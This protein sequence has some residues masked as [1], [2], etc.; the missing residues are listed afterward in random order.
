MPPAL[1]MVDVRKRYGANRAL[2][3]LNLE[4][5]TGALTGLVG[6]NGA[7]KTTTFAVVGGSVRPDG[8]QVDLLGEGPFDPD[9]HAGRLGLLPQDCE[10]SPYTPVR[11]LLVHY[12]R[13]QGMERRKA[14]YHA[15]R[16]LEAVDLADRAGAKIR[17][18]SHGMRRR[19]AVAQALLGDPSL[20]LLD[21]PTSGL[22]PHLVVRMRELFA[23]ERGRR[24]LVISSHQLAELEAVCDHVVFMEAGRVVRAGALAEVT[25]RGTT[26]RISLERQDPALLARAEAVARSTLPDATVALKDG[27]LV[28]DAPPGQDAGRLNAA[29]LP[30]LIAAGLPIH[31]VRAGTSLEQRYMESRG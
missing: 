8:G 29:L 7:G 5:P 4:I 26:V 27:L 28:V 21:E 30:A 2:D 31:E 9:R 14:E 6:P 12:G 1:R 13:L 17:Q 22:D 25:G 16:A 24:T 3:G 10:L 11:L 15:D 20:V 18:L 19:V 23:A